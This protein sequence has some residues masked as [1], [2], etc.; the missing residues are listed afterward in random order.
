M[1]FPKL[2]VILGPTATGKTK[3]AVALARKFNGEIVS[4]DSR[5]VYRGMDIGTGKDLAEYGKGKNKIPY[6]LINIVKPVT[7][8]NAGKFKKRPAGSINKILSRNK[9]PFLVGGTGLY[10]SALIDNY[11]FPNLSSKQAKGKAKYQTLQIGLTY[12][13]KILNKKIEQ[14]V[15]KMIENGMINETKK[16]VK[17]YPPLRRAGGQYAAPLQTIG[18]REIINYLNN[19]ETRDLAS[20]QQSVDLIKLH[21][22]QFAKRQMTWFKGHG[23]RDKHI[24]SIKNQKEA[25]KLIK[26]FLG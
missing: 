12:P 22:R 8:F 15:D 13:K 9:I 23:G 18:Y 21:T 25:E 4:A 2:I 20:L 11:Q 17:K 16:L 14:R 6:H 7:Q 10:I 19:V 5:Q 26:K 3:L 1:P 24:H